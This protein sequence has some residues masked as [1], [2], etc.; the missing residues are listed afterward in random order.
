MKGR[1][2]DTQLKE[3]CKRKKSARKSQEEALGKAK[4]KQNLCG[5]LFVE[6]RIV[7]SPTRRNAKMNEHCHRIQITIIKS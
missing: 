5:L 2:V 7:E 4:I 3:K 6:C 1:M